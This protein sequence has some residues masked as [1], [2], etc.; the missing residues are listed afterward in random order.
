MALLKARVM[1][2]QRYEYLMKDMDTLRPITTP[3]PTAAARLHLLDLES[4]LPDVPFMT[5]GDS[6]RTPRRGAWAGRA[7]HRKEEH[8]SSEDAWEEEVLLN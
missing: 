3:R 1:R 2:L 7:E 8:E 5:T 6:C 4:T